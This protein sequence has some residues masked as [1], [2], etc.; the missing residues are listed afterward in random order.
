[1][2]RSLRLAVAII[3][4][5]AS[6][7][8]F[9]EDLASL[10]FKSV[11]S[12]VNYIGQLADNGKDKNGTGIRRGK[13]GMVYIGDF[14]RGKYSGYGMMIIGSKGKIDNAPGAAVYVGEWIDNKK[15]GR[16]VCYSYD[17]DIIYEGNFVD[18][19]PSDAYPTPHPDASKYFSDN[20]T[21]SGEYYIGE[22][23]NGIPNGFGLFVIDEGVFSIGRTRNGVR[24]GVGLLLVMDGSW[25]SVKWDNNNSY[26]EISSSE[27]YFARKE[28]YREVQSKINA[29]LK[30]AMLG[31]ANSAMQLVGEYGAASSGDSSYSSENV[32]S[33]GGGGS[34]SSGKNKSSKAGKTKS[35]DCG[36]AW[37]TASRT[38][39]DYE[40]QLVPNGARS[41]TD[42][43]RR[44]EIKSK[45]RS[46][47]QKWEQ[48]G[49]PITKSP[50]ED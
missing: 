30:D 20:E 7:N 1:M 49:C 35:N 5:F 12:K 40:S 46:L 2:K 34:A 16:G 18:D 9:A 11:D 4:L 19:V 22:L 43:S 6:G 38:Y 41:V 8:L 33:D 3:L 50:Y 26:S 32:V 23:M 42:E 45:M 36:S 29:E 27:E 39:S 37:H 31:L 48:R 15:N 21:V 10:L 28:Q 24:Y 17:G 13:G 25:M 47:R 44:R 14:M